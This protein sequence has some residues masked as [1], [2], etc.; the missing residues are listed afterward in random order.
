MRKLG[1]CCLLLVLVLGAGLMPAQAAELIVGAQVP[2][3]LEGESIEHLDTVY[4]TPS[5]GYYLQWLDFEEDAGRFVHYREALVNPD[6]SLLW[7]GEYAKVAWGDEQSTAIFS[8]RDEAGW[9]QRYYDGPDQEATR[10]VARDWTGQKRW[11][12]EIRN[13]A[14]NGKNWMVTVGDWLLTRWDDR[15]EITI[16][17]LLGGAEQT[18]PFISGEVSP[19][20]AALGDR[21]ALL[22]EEAEGRIT[23]RF[24]DREGQLVGEAAMPFDLKEMETED[25]CLDTEVLRGT[26]GEPYLL[27]RRMA[28]RGRHQG[29]GTCWCWTL[30]PGEETFE[31]LWEIPA[32]D[33]QTAA[34]WGS[35]AVIGPEQ[36]LTVNWS[37]ELFLMTGAG[38]EKVELVGAKGCWLLPAERDGELPVLILQDSEG[39][40]WAQE[41]LGAARDSW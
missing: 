30:P 13:Y 31:T 15:G 40:L 9:V 27:L 25:T 20:F 2:L 11:D 28:W 5:G 17:P 36:L 23:C 35:M 16:Q 12:R 6:G 34:A 22:S 21:L 3:Q 26:E 29:T 38:V 41:V 37:G 4:R 14:V 1:W 32:K 24:F 10:E 18:Y 8:Y 39:T 19:C 33:E 7:R